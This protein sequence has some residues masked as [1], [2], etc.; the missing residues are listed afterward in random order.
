MKVSELL[1]ALAECNP[2]SEIIVSDRTSFDAMESIMIDP[3]THSDVSLVFAFIQA[4]GFEYEHS[5]ELAELKKINDNLA[6]LVITGRKKV[7]TEDG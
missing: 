5:N 6:M 3:E 7:K 1:L 4:K 2:D